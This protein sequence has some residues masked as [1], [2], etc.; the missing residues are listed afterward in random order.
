MS[1]TSLLS[2]RQILI[3]LRLLWLDSFLG[4]PYLLL[5]ILAFPAGSF[6]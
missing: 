5:V 4:E 6:G 1:A 3:S 2:A